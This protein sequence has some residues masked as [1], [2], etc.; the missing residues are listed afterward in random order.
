MEIIINSHDYKSNIFVY[1][2]FKATLEETFC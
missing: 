2:D 1:K